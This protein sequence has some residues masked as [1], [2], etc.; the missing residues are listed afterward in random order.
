M[1]TP[2]TLVPAALTSVTYTT[3]AST[4]PENTLASVDLTSASRV[5]GLTVTCALPNTAAAVT[6]HGTS[7]SHSA[8][9]TPDLARS[10]RRFTRPGVVGGGAVSILL[11][12]DGVGAVLFFTRSMFFGAGAAKT[13]TG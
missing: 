2:R 1:V 12:A 10:A 13:S 8:T 9:L 5:T 6:P 4:L 11:L 3:A 7:W